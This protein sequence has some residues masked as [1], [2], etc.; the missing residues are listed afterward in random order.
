MLHRALK[1]VRL[2]LPDDFFPAIEVTA[3]D[4]EIYRLRAEATLRATLQDE[5]PTTRFHPSRRHEQW[6]L[7]GE[8][9]G[10]QLYRERGVPKGNAL[11]LI[12]VGSLLCSLEE[13]MWGLHAVDTPN[14]K[15]QRSIMHSDFLDAA[16]LH[17]LQADECTDEETSLLYRFSG[18]KWLAC[19]PA[20]TLVHKRDLCWYE[21]MGMMSDVNGNDLGFLVMESVRL[22]TCPPFDR[23]GVIRST[24]SVC[25]IFRRLPTGDV[26]LYMKGEHVLGGKLRSWSSDAVMSEMW[27]AITNVLDCVQSKRLSRLVRAPDILS[28]TTQSKLCEICDQRVSRLKSAELCKS[29]GKDQQAHDDDKST[30][31]GKHGPTV[32]EVSQ[33]D[34]TETVMCVSSVDFNDSDEIVEIPRVSLIA[35]EPEAPG[36]V[37]H[38]DNLKYINCF[39][40]DDAGQLANARMAPMEGSD[41]QQRLMERLLQANMTAEATYLIA[42]YNANLAKNSPCDVDLGA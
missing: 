10:V 13:V 1:E 9:H 31:D 8:R 36:D 33:E 32:K 22:D 38:H 41:E 25:Y 16:V 2:P 19:A 35:E 30:N 42:K 11:Q 23:H 40:S 34:P 28:T 20:G 5:H 14:F 24:V 3:A 18:L 7:A 17:V 21:S 4:E 37:F 27:L 15:T 39:A 12:C 26:G 6:K 29:C